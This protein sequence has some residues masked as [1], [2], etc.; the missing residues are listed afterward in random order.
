MIAALVILMIAASLFALFEALYRLNKRH[1]NLK[2][3]KETET[4]SLQM[5]IPQIM[6]S[7]L[8]LGLFAFL[9]FGIK[10]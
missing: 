5:L 7:L 10:K 1:V 6:I 9:T 2:A 3:G 4:D 8:F